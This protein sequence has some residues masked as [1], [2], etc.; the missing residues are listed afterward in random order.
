MTGAQSPF[1]EW[2]TDLTEA[3]WLPCWPRVSPQQSLNKSPTELFDFGVYAGAQGSSCPPVSGPVSVTPGPVAESRLLWYAVNSHDSVETVG[4]DRPVH[5][6]SRVA[7]EDSDQTVGHRF[8]KSG[9]R[10]PVPLPLQLS[11]EAGSGWRGAPFSVTAWSLWILSH[12]RGLGAVKEG[13]PA[14]PRSTGRHV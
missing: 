7:R 5:S 12:L 14:R 4:A 3:K 10:W 1:A 9:L 11:A 2:K 8:Q 6:L 13:S